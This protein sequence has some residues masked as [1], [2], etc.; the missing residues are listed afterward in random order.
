MK[1]ITNIDDPRYVKAMSHPLRVRLL[2]M[3]HE[4]KASPVVL[5]ERLG[6]SLGV[7]AYHVRTLE[8]LGLIEL[9]GE[10]R[11]RGAVE[12]HYQAKE[13]PSV[14]DE[15]WGRASPIAKQAAVGASLQII[16]EYARASAAAGGFDRADTHLTR[17]ILRLDEKGYAQLAKACKRLLNEVDRIE[18]GAAARIAR[19]PHAEGIVD[20]GVVM[21]LF[22]AVRL[23][24]QQPA[25]G[26]VSR[27]AGQKKRTPP[28]RRQAGAW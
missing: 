15:A 3:L 14:S 5:A 8:R 6:T 16:D 21:M 20:A 4:Q 28:R 26:R 22:E 13:R 1:P 12:H 11:K 2:A 7:V 25:S 10:S 9:V 17:T 19:D 24:Q 23:S 18:E 27:G